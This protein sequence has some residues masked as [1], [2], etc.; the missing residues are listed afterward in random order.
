MISSATAFFTFSLFRPYRI[1]SGPM[2]SV[3]LCIIH[4][5]M[6]Q[7]VN[8][9]VAIIVEFKSPKLNKSFSFVLFQCRYQVEAETR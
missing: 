1:T 3:L 7:N 4:K 2:T 8:A 9:T 6:I 5:L